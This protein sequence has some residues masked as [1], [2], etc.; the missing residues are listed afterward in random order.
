MLLNEAAWDTV[1]TVVDAG[2]GTGTLPSEILKAQPEVRGTLGD[3]PRTTARSRNTFEAA[4][5]A[6]R[7]TIACQSFFDP[8]PA[9]GDLYVLKSV[10][11]DWPD[12]QAR[13]I[14]R[15]CGDAAQPNG[16]VAV[17]DVEGDCDE[18]SPELLMMVLVGGRARTLRDFRKLAGEAG[19]EVRAAGRGTSGRFIVECR[20]A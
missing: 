13:T 5:V 9:G 16:I 18:A 8:L 17:L 7:A 20:P 11:S 10:L 3:L 2:G 12:D 15:R 1:R 14:L 4:G 19:L 6:D